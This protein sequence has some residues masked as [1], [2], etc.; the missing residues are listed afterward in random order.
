MWTVAEHC[1][2]VALRS[3]RTDV[4]CG[5]LVASMP[6]ASASPDPPSVMAHVTGCGYF[7]AP[8]GSWKGRTKKMH[9]VSSS[10]Y[11]AFTRPL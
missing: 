6:L 3:L 2:S 10:F 7:V 11:K 8:P 1:S 9:A 5:R 4:G